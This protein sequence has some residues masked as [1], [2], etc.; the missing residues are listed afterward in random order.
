MVLRHEEV[1]VAI[2]VQGSEWPRLTKRH[3]ALEFFDCAIDELPNTSVLYA[4]KP[5][6]IKTNHSTPPEKDG[7][8][9]LLLGWQRTHYEVLAR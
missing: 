8:T 9:E 2:S 7:A 1:D 5:I 6:T 4:E 3:H